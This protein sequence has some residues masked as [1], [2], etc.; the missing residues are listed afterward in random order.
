MRLI[1][2]NYFEQKRNHNKNVRNSIKQAQ[3]DRGTNSSF[4]RIRE[5]KMKTLLNIRAKT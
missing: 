3:Q 5:K 2:E 1:G 4:N